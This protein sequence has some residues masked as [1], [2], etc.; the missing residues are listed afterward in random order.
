MPAYM[1]GVIGLTLKGGSTKLPVA[2][3]QQTSSAA[4][5]AQ[6]TVT[7]PN[8]KQTSYE[9]PTGINA[10]SLVGLR[11]FTDTNDATN[12]HFI[13]VDPTGAIYLATLSKDA[14]TVSYKRV[15]P[16]E[17]YNARYNQTSCSIK[18]QVAFCYRGRNDITPKSGD[19]FTSPSLVKLDFTSGV[20]STSKVNGV[21]VLDGLY[22]TTSGKVYGKNGNA[23]YVFN[24]ASDN[25]SVEQV[26]ASPEMVTAGANLYFI[27]ANGVYQLDDA[28]HDSHQIFYSA[29]LVVSGVYPVDGKVFVF[30]A[31]KNTGTAVYAY[32]MTSTPDTTPGRRMIDIL[33]FASTAVKNM[34][35]NDFVGSKVLIGM[36]AGTTDYKT[37]GADFLNVL[38]GY[39]ITLPKGNITLTN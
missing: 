6:V 12:G 31:A 23:L 9:T 35:F 15:A 2:P 21:S 8:G 37:V 11:V 1:G 22:A 32:V 34:I 14:S 19:T 30:A 29:N 39:G 36:S 25:Y 33:P 27:Q 16:A 20:V 17:D 26:A 18:G 24:S 5:D 7:A 3:S 10:Y 28:T 4:N 13:L 38:S